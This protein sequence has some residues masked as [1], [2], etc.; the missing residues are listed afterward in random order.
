M[1]HRYYA[2]AFVLVLLASGAFA[3]TTVMPWHPGWDYFNR[4]LNYLTSFAA[5]AQAPQAKD[6]SVVYHLEHA[7]PHTAH[8]V[9]LNLYWG[10]AG[11]PSTGLCVPHFGQF[12][13][14]N[15]A[16]ACR[17]NICRTYNSFELGALATGADGSALHALTVHGLA[18]GIYELQ[19]YVREQGTAN[20]GVIY[21]SPAPYGVGTV[22]ITVAAP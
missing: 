19:F 8:I 20:S 5:Y 4:P 22:F 12:P 2:I 6:L 18:P 10:P 17:Q 16:Y 21:Q 14:S 15:C 1:T 9:G 11:T 13:A 3:Q 7:L